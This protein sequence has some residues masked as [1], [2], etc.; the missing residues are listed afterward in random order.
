MSDIV[1][2][3]NPTPVQK[4]GSGHLIPRHL[5]P[6]L[7]ILFW[8]WVRV[9]AGMSFSTQEI[10]FRGIQCRT[11]FCNTIVFHNHRD[12]IHVDLRAQSLILETYGKMGIQANTMTLAYWAPVGHFAM[13]NTKAQF[14]DRF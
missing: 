1:V 11:P 2:R 10:K 12:S 3:I 14:F 4:M 7:E 9:R 5:I 8:V 6:T 13:T